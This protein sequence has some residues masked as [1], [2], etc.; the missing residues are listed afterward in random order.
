MENKPKWTQKRKA[1]ENSTEGVAFE[2]HF[3]S[4]KINWKIPES[5]LRENSAPKF[6]Y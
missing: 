3:D 2:I 6:C 5:K 1:V 4:E